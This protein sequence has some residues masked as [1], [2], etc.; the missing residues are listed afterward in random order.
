MF[1]IIISQS[2][3]DRY[4]WMWRMHNEN[5]INYLFNFALHLCDVHLRLIKL[6]F[7]FSQSNK[8]IKRGVLST[9]ITVSF[10]YFNQMAERKNNVNYLQKNNINWNEQKKLNERT[11][12]TMIIF[13]DKKNYYVLFSVSVC[14]FCCLVWNTIRNKQALIIYVQALFWV[15]FFASSFAIFS[16][17]VRF[18]SQNFVFSRFRHQ[19]NMLFLFCVCC[20]NDFKTQFNRVNVFETRWEWFR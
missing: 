16:L 4:L 8:K 20:G 18:N 14:S 3:S 5:V 2:W 17:F 7:S 13:D 6:N 19:T 11:N 10:K 15:F 9:E 1:C 12:E